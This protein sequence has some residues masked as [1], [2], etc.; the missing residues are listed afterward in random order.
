[1]SGQGGI[2]NPGQL[3]YSAGAEQP[4]LL[5]ERYRIQRELGRGGFGVA[6]LASDELL[7]GRQVVIKCPLG[8]IRPGVAMQERFEQEIAVLAMIQHP[9]VVSVTDAGVD[10][11]G[12]PFLVMEF[13]DGVELR[14]L[15]PPNGMRFAE[16][17]DIIRQIGSALSAAHSR[18]VCH[19]D[20]KPENILIQESGSSRFLK[21]IDFGIASITDGLQPKETQLAGTLAYMSPEQLRGQVS[22]FTD[23]WATVVIAYELL[24]G[25]VPFRASNP[26]DL[27]ARQITGQFQPP[28]ELRPDLPEEA[29]AILCAALAAAEGGSSFQSCREFAKALADALTVSRTVA[30]REAMPRRSARS[31]RLVA[32]LCN[33]RTQED[34]FRAFF[35]R[36]TAAGSERPMFVFVQGQEGS[37]H[38]SLVERLLYSVEKSMGGSMALERPAAKSK[39][40]PWQYEGS[41]ESRLARLSSWLFDNLSLQATPAPAEYSAE[42]LGQVLAKFKSRFLVLEHDVRCAKWD[43]QA[44]RLLAEYVQLLAGIPRFKTSPSLLVFFNLVYPRSTPARGISSFF[45]NALQNRAKFGIQAE[46]SRI[47]ANH[48]GIPMLCLPELGEITKDDVLE[49]FSLHEIYDSE[50]RRLRVSEELFLGDGGGLVRAKQMAEVEAKL[51]DIHKSFLAEMTIR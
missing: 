34:D 27:Y 42:L 29:N 21:V 26:I 25:V 37:C 6:Y 23:L 16:V 5:K 10:S 20:L 39:R 13:I 50:E 46:V 8:Q 17:A 7:Y 35:Q 1:M 45:S 15:I 19:R 14:R 31:G 28:S 51:H 11:R 40:V 44:S 32:K 9:A 36:H 12:I 47:Q 24:T 30:Q 33:R 22:S 2:R 38:E 49:W 18:N 48:P 43:K 41:V 4:A 3:P